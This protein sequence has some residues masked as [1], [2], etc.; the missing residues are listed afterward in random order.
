MDE[1]DSTYGFCQRLD[2]VRCIRMGLVTYVSESNIQDETER[3]VNDYD[4][5]CIG[6]RTKTLILARDMHMYLTS[7]HCINM[8][9]KQIT[10][11]TSVLS[12]AEVIKYAYNEFEFRLIL[13]ELFP[14]YVLIQK[15]HWGG[16]GEGGNRCSQSPE[17][18][19]S[20]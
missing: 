7:S 6:T 18:D 2:Y 13:R 17:G 9:H 10:P 8:S 5:H 12:R 4:R 14:I 19:N 20:K 11:V 15:V 16:R 1:R 3:N